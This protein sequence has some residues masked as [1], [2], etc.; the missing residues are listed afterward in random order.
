M[1]NPLD[2]TTGDV[3]SS[4]IG[5]IYFLAWTISFYPQIWLNWRR[6]SVVGL[7]FDYIVF[8]VIGFA[9]YSAFNLAF[10]FSSIIQDQY[11]EQNNGKENLVQIN[12]VFFAVHAF[13]ATVVTIAQIIFYEKGGQ[14]VSKVCI[15]LSL[16]GI[17]SI[18]IVAIVAAVNKIQWLWFFYYLSYVKLA[19]SFLKYCPQVFLNFRRKSTIGWN[20]WNVLLDFTGGLLSVLQLLFDGWRTDNWTGVSGDPVKF[21]LGFMSMVFDLIFMVQHYGFYRHSNSLA[22]EKKIFK[23]E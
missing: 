14:R 1:T 3:I 13:A 4:V 2:D 18:I 17:L 10:Y 15:L 22:H 16:C 9:C 19:I 23:V 21:G 8:N 20:I 5:W 12:D 11:K 7:A 6:K